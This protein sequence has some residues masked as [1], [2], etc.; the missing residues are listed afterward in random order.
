MKDNCFKDDRWWE[1]RRIDIERAAEPTNVLWENMAV[2]PN[3]RFVKALGTY[4]LAFICLAVVFAINLGLSFARDKL[5]KNVTTKSYSETRIFITIILISFTSSIIIAINNTILS[6]VIRYISQFERHETYTKYNLTVSL[7]LTTS[8]L[9]NT[10][11]IPLVVNLREDKW[12]GRGGLAMDMFFI[13]L[14][15]N[16]VTPSISLF[17]P[18]HF[19]K[20]IRFKLE[21]NKG[22]NSMKTQREANA[23]REGVMWNPPYYYATTMVTFAI[24]CFYTPL[25][26]MLSIISLVGITYKYWV[27]KYILLRR[28]Q[29][30]NEMADQMAKAFADLI[31][32]CCFFYALGQ[33][34]FIGVLSNNENPY[35]FIALGLTVIFLL[36]PFG[37]F[38]GQ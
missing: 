19:L 24:T 10:G 17:N 38:M 31:P 23:L 28:C 25:I 9:I 18:F 36:F 2:K 34:F 26:P 37:S 33:W 35:P 6:K 22:K 32:I 16:F 3:E 20:L 15:I 21:E 5:D 12:F 4:G 8:M 1:G 11:I 30:P 29:M 13:V 7:K 27:E 14:T